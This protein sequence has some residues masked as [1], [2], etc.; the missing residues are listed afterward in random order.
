MLRKA[1][2]SLTN[3]T[4]LDTNARSP[5]D[6][7]LPHAVR[8]G[9]AF[10]HILEAIDASWLPTHGGTGATVVVTMTL[11][12]LI[13]KLDL[14][15]VCP[16]DTGGRISAGDARRL[17]RSAGIIPVVLGAKSVILDAGTKTRFHTG[18]QRIA[19][20]A[21]DSGCTAHGCDVP[22]AMCHAHPDIAFSAGGPTSVANGAA[23]SADTI[24]DASTTRPTP[25]Q[26][27]TTPPSPSTDEPRPQ[28]PTSSSRSSCGRDDDA[29]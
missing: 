13:G 4:R 2:P 3:P 18:P 10:T 28:V 21:R 9:V 14:A 19:R 12:Q 6:T 24:T 22:A 1:I 5:I 27:S 7:D 8:D 17:A 29:P 16:I 23:C 15:G 11:D 26:P 20:G 25:P